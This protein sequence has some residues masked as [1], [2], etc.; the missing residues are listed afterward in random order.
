MNDE[1]LEIRR[2]LGEQ[3][4]SVDSC[5][6][7]NWRIV[8]DAGAEDCVVRGL[9]TR[10]QEEVSNTLNVCLYDGLARDK[11]Q[12]R[13][14]YGS[15]REDAAKLIC[16]SQ[17][18]D[19]PDSVVLAEVGRT[20]GD[21]DVYWNDTTSRRTSQQLV[22]NSSKMVGRL[23]KSTSRKTTSG[24]LEMVH[25]TTRLATRTPHTT[26]DISHNSVRTKEV[27]S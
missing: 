19:V 27:E 3:L 24:S 21:A 13:R 5:A 10:T 22:C 2:T 18:Q 4:T 7:N 14:S 17:I 8:A 6:S 1:G 23:S 20:L 15:K 12:G 25:T 16:N 26:V 11:T 9:V